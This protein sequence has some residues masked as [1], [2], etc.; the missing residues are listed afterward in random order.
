LAGFLGLTPREHS[1]GRIRRLG[2]IGKRGDAYLRMLLIHGARGVLAQAGSARSHDRL[3]VW[4]QRIERELR[5]RAMST[6][7]LAEALDKSEGAIRARLSGRGRRGQVL[8]LDDGRWALPD[9]GGRE[10]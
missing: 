10:P 7:E 8:R 1:S 3:R 9:K 4:T 5:A 6:R 2:A